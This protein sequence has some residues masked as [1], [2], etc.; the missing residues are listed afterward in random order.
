MRRKPLPDPDDYSGLTEHQIQAAMFRAFKA[1]RIWPAVMF[2]IPN[3]GA[4]QT[5]TGKLL[6]REGVKAGIPD[7]LV[8]VDGEHTFIEVKTEKGRLRSAQKETHFKIIQAGGVVVTVYGLKQ[9]LEI[10]ENLGIISP[11]SVRNVK[12]KQAA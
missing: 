12:E 1:R 7:I 9:A 3:G 8:I 10:L 5:V 2:A 11:P 6:K 4:R